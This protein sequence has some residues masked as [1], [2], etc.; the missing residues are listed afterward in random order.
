[1]IVVPVYSRTRAG[2][3]LRNP[4]PRDPASVAQVGDGGPPTVNVACF[5][6][7][8]LQARLDRSVVHHLASDVSVVIAAKQEALSLGDV[9]NRTRPYAG[10]MFVVVGRST[11]GTSE[12]AEQSGA[13]VLADGGRGKG[14]AIRRA[15]P[16]I[17]RP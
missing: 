17:Q 5:S 13:R 1:M 6:D 10:E 14:E 4:P 7:A 11:D 2:R 3:D 15:I 16:C 9:V 12:V 8:V